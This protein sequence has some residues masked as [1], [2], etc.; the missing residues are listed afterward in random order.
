LFAPLKGAAALG[1]ETGLGKLLR[2]TEQPADPVHG[3]GEQ[4]FAD[5]VPGEVLLLQQQ[6][7][8]ALRGDQGGDSRATRTAAHDHDIG[9]YI[10]SR[11]S[12]FCRRYEQ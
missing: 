12:R 11:A 1:H 2:Y 7:T 5:L 9:V 3:G 10:H 4:G 8:V 6:H